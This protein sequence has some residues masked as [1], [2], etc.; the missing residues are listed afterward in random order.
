MPK[1]DIFLLRLFFIKLYHKNNNYSGVFVKECPFFWY[2]LHQS[3]IFQ[4]INL[5]VLQLAANWCILI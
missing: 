2:Y 4:K 5:T 3:K 1:F